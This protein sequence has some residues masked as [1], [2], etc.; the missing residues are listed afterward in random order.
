MIRIVL[1]GDTLSGKTTLF[2]TLLYNK[3]YDSFCTTVS[4]TFAIY[5][6]KYIFYDTPGQER[7]KMFS[8]RYIEIADAAI[9]MFDVEEGRN[10]VEKWKS[11]VRNINRKK[12]PTLLVANVRNRY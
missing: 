12:I 1:L 5:S 2:D 6:E 11:H 3:M 4:P 7:W 9:I 8:K 10:G